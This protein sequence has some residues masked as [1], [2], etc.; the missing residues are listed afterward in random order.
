M[1]LC[2]ALHCQQNLMQRKQNSCGKRRHPEILPACRNLGNSCSEWS[3]CILHRQ[4]R[5]RFNQRYKRSRLEQSPHTWMVRS[6]NLRGFCF[7]HVFVGGTL[8]MEDLRSF[9]VR[10][11][12][13]WKV[14]LGNAHMYIPPPP[15]GGALLAFILKLMKGVCTEITTCRNF[16]LQIT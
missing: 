3:R 4:D 9:R 6:Q 2:V 12:N 15:A 8:E 1:L 5:T 11:E 13:A 16:C 14:S 10:E 7:L